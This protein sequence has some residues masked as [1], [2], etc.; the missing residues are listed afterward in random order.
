MASTSEI[1]IAGIVFRSD[2]VTYSPAPR[3][4]ATLADGR[5][6]A[7]EL[8]GEDGQLDWALTIR[9]PDGAKDTILL[10]ARIDAAPEADLTRSYVSGM[11][12]LGAT[13]EQIV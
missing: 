3:Y 11:R 1:V 12:A 10:S 8:N 6:L 5:E 13:D 4:A 7:V 9:T 2:R